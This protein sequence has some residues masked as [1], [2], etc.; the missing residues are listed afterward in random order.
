MEESGTRIADERSRVGSDLL[1][2]AEI[3]CRDRIQPPAAGTGSPAISLRRWSLPIRWSRP[4]VPKQRFW[5]GV[6]CWKPIRT[7]RMCRR[8]SL[9]T[10]LRMDT[11]SP[12]PAH[13]RIE[14]TNSLRLALGNRLVFH[15]SW[16]RPFGLEVS[17]ASGRRAPFRR[18]FSAMGSVFERLRHEDAYRQVL[19]KI[20]I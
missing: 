8:G 2:L 14:E 10:R 1:L 5:N 11:P 13:R 3:R 16:R 6:G 4:D 19:K 18:Y 9:F 12:P 15:A 17:G 7:T 20:G